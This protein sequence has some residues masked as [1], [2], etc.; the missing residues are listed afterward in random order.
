MGA[1]DIRGARGVQE[2]EEERAGSGR[3]RGKFATGYY[4]T[5]QKGWEPGMQGTEGER[6]GCPFP[7]H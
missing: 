6:F 4:F 3:S 5:S 1:C 7:L 2:A